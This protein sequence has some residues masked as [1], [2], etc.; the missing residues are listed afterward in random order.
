MAQRY[1]FFNAIIENGK[2]DRIYNA[3]DVNDFFK[4][5]LSDGIFKEVGNALRVESGEDFSVNV[6]TG[7]AL[8]AQHWYYNDNIVNL[9]ITPAHITYNRYTTVIL[10]CDKSKRSITLTTLDGTVSDAPVPPTLTQNENIYEIAIAN[11]LVVTGATVISAND[12]TDMR[13]YVSGLVD[14]T[15]LKYRRYDYTVTD[16]ED[17][18]SYFDIPLSYNL[19]LD[20]VLQVYSN[21]LMC[22]P[23]EYSLMVNEVEGNYM[24]VFNTKRTKGS[25][26][27][28]IMIN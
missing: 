16:Y 18:Q 24:V 9:K 20:T 6:N 2:A 3:D 25:E 15:P 14:P 7:K 28:F 27:S 12:I 11:I 4:G 10:R 1:G 5:L 21:G 23:S 26:L 8:V 22:M 17:G 13:S 19:T